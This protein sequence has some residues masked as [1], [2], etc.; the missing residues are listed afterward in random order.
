MD[1]SPY[2]S[3]H[4]A[5]SY[6][7]TIRRVCEQL[8][9]APYDGFVINDSTDYDIDILDTPSLFEHEPPKFW[10]FDNIHLNRHGNEVLFNALINKFGFTT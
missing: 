3:I 10:R 8:G 7:R 4:T 9:K 6:N 1:V 5:E 2:T